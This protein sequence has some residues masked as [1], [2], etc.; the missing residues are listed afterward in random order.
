MIVMIMMMRTV[1]HEG[2]KFLKEILY[3]RIIN[4]K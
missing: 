1:E 4:E 3:T 2:Q